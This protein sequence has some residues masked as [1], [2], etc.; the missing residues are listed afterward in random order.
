MLPQTWL[1][2]LMLLWLWFGM[3]AVLALGVAVLL[4]MARCATR[5]GA[6]RL[7]PLG[8]LALLV[9]ILPQFYSYLSLAQ[10]LDNAVGGGV[11]Q[12]TR[13]AGLPGRVV[14]WETQ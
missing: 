12:G 10:Y 6:S 9:A 5:D 14:L 4:V 7:T 11:E 3:V 13:L 8:V 2:S 1:A